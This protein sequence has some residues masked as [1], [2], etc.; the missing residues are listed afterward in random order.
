MPMKITTFLRVACLCLL[1]GAGAWA[2]SEAPQ[3]PQHR[4]AEGTE[5]AAPAS[6]AREVACGVVRDAVTC[7]PL[8]GATV[9]LRTRQGP[10]IAWCKTDAKGAYLLDGRYVK[11]VRL[12]AYKE[13]D[14]SL[15]GQI[16]RGA[17]TVLGFAAKSAGLLVRPVVRAA[18]SAVGGPL[19]GE[20]AAHVAD[21]V[22][23]D[24]EEHPLELPDPDDPAVFTAKVVCPGYK[25][26]HGPVQA[27]W[28]TPPAP[29]GEPVLTF[30][31]DPFAL[32]PR[33]AATKRRSGPHPE[34]MRLREATL[35]PSIAP[36]GSEF[37]VSV[38]LEV[39]A[40]AKGCVKV[41]ARHSESG[42][43]AELLPVRG[44]A[45]LFQGAMKVADEWPLNDQRIV[46]LALRALPA[47]P[48]GLRDASPEEL[49]EKLS[50]WKSRK[51]TFDPQILASR[52]REALTL[53]VVE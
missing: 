40:P 14:R 39:P 50:L 17:D 2:G 36:R 18:G 47:S 8:P 42:E 20:V 12:P 33:E 43:T 25:D 29:E 41:L 1:T 51:L 30:W 27:Y 24:P 34:M 3:T 32:V 5:D 21:A 52:D 38:R 6:P 53:T 26:Y 16:V 37:V 22:V 23:P 44:H 4:G 45:G 35:E 28:I 19:V 10:V 11:H 7:A 31:L 15:L 13:K 49:A 9:A 48:E 46:V